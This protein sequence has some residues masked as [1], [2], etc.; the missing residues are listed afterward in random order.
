METCHNFPTWIPGAGCGIIRLI[1]RLRRRGGRDQWGAVGRGAAAVR[2]SRHSGC[3]PRGLLRGDRR[4][5]MHHLIM[6][7]S[8]DYVEVLPL[9]VNCSV[10]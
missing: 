7:L 4:Q 3:G 10:L 8:V 9:L 6:I 5:G 2:G 1:I